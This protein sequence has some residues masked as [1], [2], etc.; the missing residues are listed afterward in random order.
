MST[1]VERYL[2]SYIGVLVV[3]YLAVRWHRLAVNEAYA[4]G[5]HSGVGFSFMVGAQGGE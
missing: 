5:Y 2:L 1:A 4:S 3:A